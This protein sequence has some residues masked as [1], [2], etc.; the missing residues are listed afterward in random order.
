MTSLKSKLTS[1]VSIE[2][3]WQPSVNCKV[4][5]TLSTFYATGGVRWFQ[6][7]RS[8]GPPFS[9]IYNTSHNSKILKKCLVRSPKS[10]VFTSTTGVVFEDLS[11][12]GGS[13]PTIMDY[14]VISQSYTALDL[15]AGT[16]YFIVCSDTASTCYKLSSEKESL[17]QIVLLNSIQSP[18]QTLTTIRDSN[19]FITCPLG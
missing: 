9:K 3:P 15:I 14:S 19:S 17:D 7:F 18:T 16:P 2:L 5:N 13:V 6:T 12:D 8:E 4:E 1:W 10:I 11:S